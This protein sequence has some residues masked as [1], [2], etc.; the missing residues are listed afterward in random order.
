MLKNIILAFVAACSVSA[1][2]DNESNESNTAN[3]ANTA[4][5]HTNLPANTITISAVVD[6]KDSVTIRGNKVWF[7]HYEGAYPRDIKINGNDWVPDWDEDQES[8][9]FTMKNPPRFLPIDDICGFACGFLSISHT[10]NATV[11]E[12]PREANEWFLVIMMKNE[13]YEPAQVDVTISWENNRM[14]V[15]II[16]SAVPHT[17]PDPTPTGLR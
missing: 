1:F 8:T 3:T 15:S 11:V 9:D 6:R 4:N 13:G 5:T 7:T 17:K 10:Q 14:P 2:A 12:Y 16:R